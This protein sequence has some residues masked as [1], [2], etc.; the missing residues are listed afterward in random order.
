MLPG[1]YG[2]FACNFKSYLL[3]KKNRKHISKCRL[4][5]V[6]PPC[7]V[8]LV[9]NLPT[10]KEKL[11]AIHHCCISAPTYVSI[12]KDTHTTDTY[13][14]RLIAVNPDYWVDNDFIRYTVTDDSQFKPWDYA[15]ISR[16]DDKLFDLDG[17]IVAVLLG[18]SIPAEI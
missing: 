18:N 4:L 6:Y 9:S 3:E 17:G 13:V 7:K 15:N 5:K 12:S 14:T 2:K 8:L 11:F 16:A 10:S 1:K